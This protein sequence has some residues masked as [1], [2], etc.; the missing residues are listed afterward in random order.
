MHPE[1]AIFQDAA[2]NYRNGLSLSQIAVKINRSKNFVRACLLREGI[3]LRNRAAEVMALRKSKKGKRGTRPYYGFAY[4]EGE[5]VKDP[6][7][8]PTLLLI[9]E[10]WKAGKTNHQIVKELGARKLLSRN[11]RSWSWAAVGNIIIRLRSG[12]VKIENS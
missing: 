11:G 1:N 7:E 10:L 6:R 12:L 8:Y 2:E 4:L 3:V 5:I 9:D